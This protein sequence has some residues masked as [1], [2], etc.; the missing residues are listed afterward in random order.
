MG[1][2]PAPQIVEQMREAL[3]Q[4]LALGLQRAA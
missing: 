4:A 1:E 3:D 2:L